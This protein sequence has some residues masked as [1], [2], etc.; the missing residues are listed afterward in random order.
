MAEDVSKS[1][2]LCPGCLEPIAPGENKVYQ[3]EAWW[4]KECW[5]ERAERRPSA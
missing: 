2:L 4:H 1:D 5:S 3:E